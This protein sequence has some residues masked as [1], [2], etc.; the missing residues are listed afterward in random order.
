MLYAPDTHDEYF[1]S[2]DRNWAILEDI[3][4]FEEA[5][6]IAGCA[7]REYDDRSIRRASNLLEAGI[8]ATRHVQRSTSGAHDDV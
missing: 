3:G 4:E 1:V 6:A 7:F 8:I 2:L 5:T